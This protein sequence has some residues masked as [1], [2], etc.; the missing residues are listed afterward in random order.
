MVDA[1]DTFVCSPKQEQVAL[2]QVQP[3]HVAAKSATQERGVKLEQLGLIVVSQHR[4]V[5]HA[6]QGEKPGLFN[7]ETLRH[8]FE[9]EL[10]CLVVGHLVEVFQQPHH[11]HVLLMPF[12]PLVDLTASAK[13]LDTQLGEAFGT[14]LFSVA[15]HALKLVHQFIETLK[16][17][18]CPSFGQLVPHVPSGMR[19]AKRNALFP[20][21][22]GKK[23]KQLDQCF[24]DAGRHVL[25][26]RIPL[27]DLTREGFLFRACVRSTLWSAKRCCEAPPANRC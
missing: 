24:E 13:K 7:G 14:H 27:R 16:A 17:L 18:V 21:S 12:Q 19:T 5:D 1:E 15:G 3:D 8:R 6:L 20:A 11:H 4:L 26:F 10:P 2:F 9:K 22:G 25:R 23:G